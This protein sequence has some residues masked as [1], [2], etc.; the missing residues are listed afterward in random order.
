[1]NIDVSAAPLTAYG[2][3]IAGFSSTRPWVWNP[4]ADKLFDCLDE[5][6]GVLQATAILSASFHTGLLG[7]GLIEA[8]GS[9]SAA[10]TN[11]APVYALLQAHAFLSAD[12]YASSSRRNWVAWSKI[13]SAS[14]VL[15][16][17]NDAGQRPMSWPGEAFGVKQLGKNCI[18]YGTGGVSMLFPVDS[19]APTFGCKDLIDVGV[20]NKNAIAGNKQKHFFLDAYS[21]LWV[22]TED[23]AQCLGYEEFLSTLTDP[24]MLY[25]AQYER[26]YINDSVKGFTLTL[27]GLGGGYGGLTGVQFSEQ[28]KLVMLHK[29]DA[30]PLLLVTDILDFG[31]RGLKSVESVQ[32][33]VDTPERLYLAV[34]FRNAKEEAF[35]TSRFVRL[36]REGVA[37]NRV[38]ALEFRIRL[39]NTKANALDIDYINISFKRSDRRFTRGPQGLTAHSDGEDA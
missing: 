17:T 6:Q 2:Q 25:D 32:V 26:V 24:I 8:T 15:D 11:S 37:F 31:Y 28:G 19:P 36:N 9:L 1:M 14:F 39:M 3:L 18:V 16:R 35:R 20:L 10:L 34:D 4:E 23:K 29:P 27:S 12:F 7:Y 22:L 21:R 5:E 38:T 13:G 30:I 33:A